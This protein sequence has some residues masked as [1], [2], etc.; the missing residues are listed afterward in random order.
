LG[1]STRSSS[2]VQSGDKSQWARS[3]LTNHAHGC[4][5]FP[6]P[7]QIFT[8]AVGNRDKKKFNSKE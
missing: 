4:K 3:R 8:T 7:W 2:Y 5:Y 1:D 6:P